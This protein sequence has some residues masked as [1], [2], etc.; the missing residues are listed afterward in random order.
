MA[1]AAGL[2]RAL[3]A[4]REEAEET[5]A[6]MAALAQAAGHA[7]PSPPV[8]V[9]ETV[10]DEA[11]A[12]AAAGGRLALG[13]RLGVTLEGVTALALHLAEA[14]LSPGAALRV[15]L[16]GAESGRVRAAWRLPAAALAPG[17]LM[18]DL[19]APLGP[20]RESACLDLLAETGAGDRLALSLEDRR[21]PPDRAV[22]V[23]EGEGPGRALALRLWTAPFGRRLLL[24]PHWDWEAVDLPLGVPARLPEPVWAAAQVAR[25]RGGLAALGE[26]PAR[27]WA[28]L[29]AGE[30]ALLRLPAVPL[31]G[32]DLLE[33]EVAVPL[34][35]AAGVEAALW[36]QPA[37]EPAPAAPGAR[38]SA[39][40]GAEGVRGGLSLALRLPAAAP[41]TACVTLALR[42]RGPTPARVEWR[43]LAGRRL[44][45]PLPP[46]APGHPAAAPPAAVAAPEAAPGLAAARL[47]EHY[48]MEGGGYRHLDIG[49]EGLRLGG[50]A[51]PR[52]RFKLALDGGA[53]RLEFRARPD[54]PTMFERWPGEA[55]DAHGP[56]F[57]LT[58]ADA[59]ALR[60][61]SERDRRLLCALLRLLPAAVATAARAATADAAEYEAWVGAARRLSAA[62]E[63]TA[64]G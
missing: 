60:L 12:I 31:A 7:P 35:D 56:F 28:A 44:A 40:R 4:L 52:V 13:Q 3:A 34:G 48:A 2:H 42:N 27:P 18:L 23:E 15:R 14:A 5:R 45:P 26:G 16:W 55:A 24:V 57:L 6:A 29:E 22:A 49:V 38:C 53:P 63:R 37:A 17:W 47:H 32:L 64:D 36:L 33:A 58:E 43:D 11:A 10:P 50:L 61:P 59:G 51:W 30:E 62:L 41:E 46:A 54:W 19:P 21:A 1:E 39:W 25:G 9:L 20:L 8:P